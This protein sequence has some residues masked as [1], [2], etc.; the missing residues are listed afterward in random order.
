MPRTF[1][2]LVVLSFIVHA[3]CSLAQFGKWFSP[4]DLSKPHDALNGSGDCAT[5]HSSGS[6][7]DKCLLCHTEIKER[8]DQNKG[9]H[10]KVKASKCGTCHV[11]HKGKNH[12]MLG[13]DKAKFSHND[14]GWPLTGSH[15]KVPC[16]NCHKQKRI[17]AVSKKKTKT[18]TYLGA[19]AT[20]TS[21]H[22]DEHKGAYG[23]ECRA[24]HDTVAWK[25]PE[26]VSSKK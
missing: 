18:T 19:N 2:T 3:P 24:C 1:F 14:T 7:H 21:C 16:E 13:L 12:D 17:H 10:A 5:C 20:C 15:A 6:P 4:G 9:F 11:E 22:K 23:T 26:P 8:L 25:A